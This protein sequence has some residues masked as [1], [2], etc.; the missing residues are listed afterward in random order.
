MPNHKTC[1]DCGAN[2]GNGE[3]CDCNGQP[4]TAP[5]AVK[6]APIIPDAETGFAVM[7]TAMRAAQTPEQMQCAG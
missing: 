3:R 1:P 5:A 6:P 7:M 4:I 2:Y